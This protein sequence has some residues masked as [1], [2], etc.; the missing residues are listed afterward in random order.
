MV[1]FS[2]VA[3][4]LGAVLPAYALPAN[5]RGAA[6]VPNAYIVTLKSGL[7]EGQVEDHLSWVSDTHAR[8]ATRR[9]LTGVE[10]VWTNS[11][12]GYSGKFDSATIED[13]KNSEHV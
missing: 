10:K 4:L 1:R 9:D 7:P 2:Q 13:I 5:K 6:I 3:L 11:F 8:R 12:Q